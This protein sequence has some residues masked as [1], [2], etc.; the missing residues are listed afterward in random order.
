MRQTVLKYFEYVNAGAWEDYL[1]LFADDV[2]MDEQLAGHLVGIDEVRK[3]IAGLR[4]APHFQNSLVDM[5]VEGEIAMARWHI[6]ADF[7]EGRL[8]DARGVNYFR[9][10]SGKIV[11]FAN[12]H[13]TRPFDVLFAQ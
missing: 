10:V 4:T 1:Q 9:I 5:V 13:D 11:Y 3:G 8:V 12:Y 2:V 6:D 7:G